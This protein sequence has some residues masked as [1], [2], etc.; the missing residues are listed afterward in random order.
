VW[1]SAIAADPESLSAA[2]GITRLA[3][4]TGDPAL[5]EE[6]SAHEARVTG[7]MDVAARLLVRSAIV[8]AERGEV[9]NA[10]R[11]LRRALE[12]NP[13]FE[14]AAAK[15]YELL[16]ARGAIDELIALLTNAANS[17]T[18]PARV[19]ALWIMASDLYAA[20]KND[21]PAALAALHR[22]QNLVPGHAGTLIKLADL[23]AS[24]QQW[25]E[26][27]DR[28]K[29]A[30]SHASSDEMRVDIHLRLAA[31]LQDQLGDSERAL[32]SLNAALALDSGSRLALSRLARLELA[33]GRGDQAAEL[34]ARLVRVS[35]E[36]SQRVDALTLL[37]DLEAGRGQYAAV[38]VRP[39]SDTACS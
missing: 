11:L 24:D 13:D 6:A 39:D 21:V 2:R 7:D 38:P 30:L 25:A 8:R 16:V 18:A 12:Q 33:R 27:V 36:L 35:P 4:R 32:A 17:A 20:R 23:Y 15:L 5:L 22:A 9:D 34:A 14:A 28:L 37:G 10:V 19:S 31:I 3:D 26:A 29:Q 1:R